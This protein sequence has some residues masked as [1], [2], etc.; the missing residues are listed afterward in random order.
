MTYTNRKR[1]EPQNVSNFHEF[2]E[3]LLT[4]ARWAAGNIVPKV[5]DD[6]SGG[7]LSRN[8]IG[9]FG[10]YVRHRTSLEQLFTRSNIFYLVADMF[11]S[12][13]LQISYAFGASSH[14]SAD[15]MKSTV[16]I[17]KMNANSVNWFRGLVNLSGRGMVLASLLSTLGIGVLL[18]LQRAC[19]PLQIASSTWGSP[20]L[21]VKSNPTPS[22]GAYQTSY[23]ALYLFLSVMVCAAMA[24]STGTLYFARST[25]SSAAIPPSGTGDIS[26]HHPSE[27]G[28]RRRKYPNFEPQ[29]QLTS[30]LL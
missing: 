19:V 25:S 16:T 15:L 30:V 6:N 12:E 24:G 28:S 8:G 7:N 10:V 27:T 23:S 14:H 4:R 11:V 26:N 29:V 17:M 22:L 21:T 3:K 20:T 5:A 18:P 9:H 2:E 13:S 1:S